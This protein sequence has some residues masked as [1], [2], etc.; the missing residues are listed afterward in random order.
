[1][2]E[3][4][5]IRLVERVERLL[6]KR[7]AADNRVLRRLKAALS[8]HPVVLRIGSKIDVKDRTNI[9]LHGVVRDV[10]VDAVHVHYQGK[11]RCQLRHP[12]NFILGEV[13]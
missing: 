6:D 7:K 12:L 9:W 8:Y 10:A 4:N 2:K 11:G 13:V 5:V 3:R 1:M